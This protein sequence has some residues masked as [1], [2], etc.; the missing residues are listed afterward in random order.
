MI[1]MISRPPDSRPGN[2][3]FTPVSQ[4]KQSTHNR[5]TR[6]INTAVFTSP[7]EKEPLSYR[8]LVN[9]R[10]HHPSS[11]P[12][13][14]MCVPEQILKH[15][16]KVKKLPTDISAA[17]AKTIVQAPDEFTRQDILPGKIRLNIRSKE[18]LDDGPDR[19]GSLESVNRFISE[20]LNNSGHK[21]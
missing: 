15:V 6:N 4:N 5:T 16:L 8:Q 18:K 9:S 3:P 14:S 13:Q 19:S 2:S 12:S 7:R 17:R 11:K 1:Q 21:M 20:A 10:G